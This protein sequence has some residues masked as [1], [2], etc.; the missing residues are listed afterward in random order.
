[1]NT[2]LN[3]VGLPGPTH[4]FGGLAVGNLAS[5]QHRFEVSHPRL[6][7]FQALDQMKL[8]HELGTPVAVMPPQPRPDREI[9]RRI[10]FRG[11]DSE[12]LSAARMEAPELFFGVFS[13]SSMWVANAATVS[14]ASDSA[15]GRIHLTPANLVS[16]F[17]RSI[18]PKWT[19]R[20]LRAIFCG[21]AFVIHPLLPGNPMFRDEGAANH[22]RLS[23]RDSAVQIFVYG[24]EGA[25][26]FPA[27]QSL[28][29]AK[30]L[31]RL[32]QLDLERTLFLEQNPRAIEAGVFHNDVISVSGG[33]LMLYHEEAFADPNAIELI[34]DL[35]PELC[36]I[37]VR[38]EDL[39]LEEAV[40]TYLFNSLILET[41]EG[42]FVLVAP[43]EV[44]QSERANACV[45]RMLGE[46]NPLVEARFV[47]VRESMKNGGGPACLRLRIPLDESALEEIRP[48][49][50]YDADLDERLRAWISE[51]YRTSLHIEDLIDPELEDEANQAW[52]G[53]L[54]ILDLSPSDL[55]VAYR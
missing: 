19:E 20:I 36:P 12:V 4:N 21:E 8:V 48:G 35:F 9:L 32:H 42:E 1:M 11:S 7:A 49:V 44:R 46:D 41:R 27:R 40:A 25:T 26:V 37:L 38:S 5:S 31:L 23:G 17:H 24:R 52:E 39:A 30:A 15:D 47:S 53:I 51:T 28:A 22:L 14:P 43:E 3:L 16:Q 2:E 33:S 13:S 45:V 18:E 34:S 29:T 54:R 50:R 55:E 10:G 6:A